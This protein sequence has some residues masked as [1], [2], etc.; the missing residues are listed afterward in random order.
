MRRTARLIVLFLLLLVAIRCG[1]NESPTSPSQQEPKEELAVQTPQD[2]KPEP[3]P[4]PKLPK[5]TVEVLAVGDIARCG[6]SEVALTAKLA[7]QFGTL[8]ILA[9]GDLAYPAN[10]RGFRECFDPTWGKLKFR[11]KPVLGNHEYEDADIRNDPFPYFSYFGTTAGPAPTGYYTFDLG[12]WQFYAL[13]SNIPAHRD[14]AQWLWLR[15]MLS[16]QKNSCTLAYWHHPL[17]SSGQNGDN[18]HM[19]DI[20]ELLYEFGAEIV[21][22]A[23]DH[24]YERFGLRDPTGRE[25]HD[26]GIRQ[27]TAGTG[28]AALYAFRTI[29]PFSEVRAA[30]HGLLKL[31]LKDD[32]YDWSFSAIAGRGFQDSSAG[33]P[34]AH[35]LCH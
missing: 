27:F 15:N 22:N 4:L 32:S 19:R 12:A 23:H 25:D 35:R 26:R 8:P 21:V 7:D 9:L 5:P 16:V 31:T 29:K 24:L 33:V 1:G 20:W 28:G 10:L 14:S 30:T 17:T 18:L 11:I 3:L 13:N 6:A 34:Q 2:P